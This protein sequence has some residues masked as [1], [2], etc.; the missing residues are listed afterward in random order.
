MRK[1]K[2]SKILSMVFILALLMATSVRAQEFYKLSVSALEKQKAVY[3]DPRPIYTDLPLKK[4][5]PSEVY[6][7]LVFDQEAMKNLW[8]EI[9]GFKAPD[10]VGKIAPE[11]KP[12]TYSYKDKEKFPFKELMIPE[13]YRRFNASVPPLALNF[14]EIKVVPTRQYY[15][16]LPIGEATK[17][18]LGKTK[19]NDQ[20]YLIYD[21]YS[22]G[23][24]FPR[25][26]GPFK[27]HQ[28]MYNW[29]K[30]YSNG[31]SYY[32]LLLTKGFAKD[33]REDFDSVMEMKMIKFEGRVLM[34]PKGWFDDR[35]K[36]NKEMRAVVNTAY[37]PR[38]LY[39][40]TFSTLNYIDP[41]KF[42]LAMMYLTVMRRV[43]K[44]SATDT[45]D[46]MGGQDLIYDDGDGFNHKLSP[47]RYSYKME[48]IGER[49]YLVPAY[50]LDGSGTVTS[51]GKELVGYEF[52]RR[53]CYVVKL[54]QQDRNYVYSSRIIYFDKETLILI[55]V[56]NFDQKGR[57]YR[58][59]DFRMVF[60]PE[61]GMF[62]V[63]DWM[64]HDHIDLHATYQRAYILPAPMLKRGDLSLGSLFKAK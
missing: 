23:I 47:T 37:S 38:D 13:H 25:P 45:Q 44:M 31:E 22:S 50:T 52:E 51:K 34:D 10:V 7:K 5:L 18:N 54:T 41:G 24:P 60:T 1:M 32:S 42:D 33:L 29:E 9:V 36:E 61:M 46:P 43:R 48:V 63:S 64:A 39:G 2:M 11:I 30:R 40:N 6:S 17:K 12:G 35:A 53:P 20:G 3:D 58:S 27:A 14:P 55:H 21:S 56:E 8:A 16:A 26:D 57:L 19:L 15:W 49:E 59:A 28:V 62:D 4:V